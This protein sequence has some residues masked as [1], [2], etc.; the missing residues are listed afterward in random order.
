[1]PTYDASKVSM[2]FEGVPL[3]DPAPS[4]TISFTLQQPHSYGIE[5]VLW[6]PRPDVLKPGAEVFVGVP[7]PWVRVREV[8]L[9]MTEAG[10]FRYMLDVVVIDMAGEGR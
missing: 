8:E 10:M 4:G 7:R 1:M 5:I 6:R 2:S 9:S 3:A